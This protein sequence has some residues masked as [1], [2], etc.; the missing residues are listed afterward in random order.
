MLDDKILNPVFKWIEKKGEHKS[1]LFLFPMVLVLLIM[2]LTISNFHHFSPHSE[3]WETV[4]L[5]S[6]DLTNT[7][8][9]LNPNS[10][11]AKK[12]YRLT[13]PI[14]IKIT[15]LPPLG[16]LFLQFIVGYL[17][18][19]M[20]FK[21]S[22][23][24]L[25]DT[26]SS[27]FMAAGIVFIY[28]GRTAFYDVYYTWFDAFAFFFIIMAIYN[29][30]ILLIFLFSTAAAWTD[31][32]AFVALFIVLIYHFLKNKNN[33][34]LEIKQIYSWNYE[35]F[36]VLS[37]IGV[38]IGTRFI[39]NYYF[40]MSTQYKDVSIFVFERTIGFMPI[41]L[42]TFFEGFWLLYL[43]YFVLVFKT[44]N[45]FAFIIG[46]FPLLVFTIISGSVTDITRS[47]SYLFPIIFVLLLY[48]REHVSN[49]Y[50]R[51]VL[52]ISFIVSVLYPSTI[53]CP[54]WGVNSWFQFNDFIKVFYFISKFWF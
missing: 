53:V 11:K 33:K 35:S 39:L 52:F 9:H 29:K 10:W 51:V 12:V 36:S 14:L 40:D 37:A 34:E 24:I 38:Y 13:I 46:F 45:Y 49:Y 20:C 3:Q 17:L 16:I 54:E 44:K 22:N 18:I 27:T 6:N 48:L 19:I 43:L 30:N 2:P 26:V 15:G 4:I 42:W 32:R 1:F 23:R 41:G 25:K 31:E 7:L 47:G 8:E 21:V 28:F 50:I 5:K